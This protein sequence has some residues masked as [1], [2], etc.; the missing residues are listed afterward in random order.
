MS[1]ELIS[2]NSDLQE[3]VATGYEVEIR[4]GHLILHRIPYVTSKRKVRFGELVTPITINGQKVGPPQD[5]TVFFRGEYPCDDTGKPIEGIRNNSKRVELAG[6]L[7]VDHRFSAKPYGRNYRDF[8]DKMTHYA[9]V[10]SRYAKRID[11][12]A[13]AQSGQLILTEDPNDPFI[14]METASSRAGITTINETLAS[15][16]IGIVGLGGTGSYILDYV[17]KTRVAE[18]HLFDGD[19]F[20]QHNAFRAPGATTEGEISKKANKAALYAAKYGEMRKGIVAHAEYVEPA[21]IEMIKKLD[22]VFI[23]IDDNE[24]RR[25][26]LPALQTEGVAFIDVGMGIER[27]GEKLLGVVRTSISTPQE[28]C[29]TPQTRKVQSENGQQEGGEYER[30]VQLVELNALNA[31]LAVIRWK[32]FRGFYLDLEGELQ[33]TYTLDGNHLSN[34]GQ[35]RSVKEG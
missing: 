26:L 4:A 8:H 21:K 7:W 11:P 25:W 5:H 34:S 10:L 22:F 19:E 9:Q 23:S 27:A 30:N 1:R 33:S 15:D 29:Y 2:H 32:K 24:T 35:A 31:A 3:L 20:Q 18:I 6:G 13:T 16:R 12:G 17:S 14:Y 28:G